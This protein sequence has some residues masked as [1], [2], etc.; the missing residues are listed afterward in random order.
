MSVRQSRPCGWSIQQ[1]NDRVRPAMRCDS[2]VHI[3]GPADR[4]RQVPNRTFTAD[5]ASVDTLQRL[6]ATRGIDRFVIVQPSFYG[7][8]NSPTL[9]A[10][11]VLA[12]NGCGVAVID[13]ATI[14]PEALADYAR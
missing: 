9:D 11:D 7:T 4:Y 12:G 13:P 10:L 6:G 1:P 5:I 14:S 8:D 2:H 3:V